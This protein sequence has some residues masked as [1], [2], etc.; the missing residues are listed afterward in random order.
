MKGGWS[1]NKFRAVRNKV[2]AYLDSEEEPLPRFK[3]KKKKKIF[4]K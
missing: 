1:N 3:K 4:T 2:Y